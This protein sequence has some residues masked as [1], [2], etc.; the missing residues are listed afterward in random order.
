MEIKTIESLPTERKSKN[1]ESLLIS[2]N[3]GGFVERLGKRKKMSPNR[4]LGS[5]S[6]IKYNSAYVYL[7]KYDVD[8]I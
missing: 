7:H 6:V 2:F 5:V 8:V 1:I 4:P 3:F